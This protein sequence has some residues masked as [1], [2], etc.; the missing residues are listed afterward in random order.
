M[1]SFPIISLRPEPLENADNAFKK[2]VFDMLFSGF[3]IIFILSWL[4]PILAILIKL[5]SKGPVFFKQLRSG[6]NNKN[7]WC[8][9]FRSMKVNSESDTKQATKEDDR[10]TMIGRF[11][12][13]TNLDEFPQFFNVLLG[14]MSIIGPR[15]HM[16]KH[17]EQ[18][19]AIIDRYMVRHYFKPGITGWAQ[20]NGFRE[21]QTLM[22]LMEAR[23]NH[24]IWY[25]ENWSLMLDI[26]IIFQTVINMFYGEKNAY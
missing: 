15:P 20:V 19:R 26:K 3:V 1:E 21:R 5:E 13:K 14:S 11:L 18:Y 22:N 17:T 8:Y 6:R 2:R 9:K 4:F 7:F 23:V 12:R 25:F 24:D 16:I 10:I